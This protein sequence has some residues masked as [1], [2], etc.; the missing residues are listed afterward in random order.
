MKVKVKGLFIQH[1]RPTSSPSDWYRKEEG[2]NALGWSGRD[3]GTRRLHFCGYEKV[4]SKPLSVAEAVRE[5]QKFRKAAAAHGLRGYRDTLVTDGYDP[6]ENQGNP[7]I[8]PGGRA[9][10]LAHLRG[11]RPLTAKK[12][13]AILVKAGKVDTKGVIG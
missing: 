10:R 13:L 6:Y 1:A 8:L 9:L 7:I 2:V 5:E 11:D 12:I 4:F 3:Y